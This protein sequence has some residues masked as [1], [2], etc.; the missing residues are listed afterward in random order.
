M[1]FSRDFVD[2]VRIGCQP[3][4]KIPQNLSGLV[5]GLPYHYAGQEAS[6]PSMQHVESNGWGYQGAAIAEIRDIDSSQGRDNVAVLVF[7]RIGSVCK[8]TSSFVHNNS[9]VERCCFPVC[10][11][12][13]TVSDLPRFCCMEKP[14]GTIH[15]PVV[16]SSLVLKFFFIAFSP[17]VMVLKGAWMSSHG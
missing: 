11:A 8:R 5:S 9:L 15:N 14:R 3:F 13:L 2:F 10:P 17:I 7:C 4:S 12:E 16:I 1:A 6:D